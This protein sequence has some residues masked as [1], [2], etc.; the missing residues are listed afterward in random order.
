MRDYLLL[1]ING[2][3]HRVRGEHVFAPLTDYLRYEIAQC[4]TKVVCAEGDCGACTVALGKLDGSEI[5]YKPVNGCIQY[6]YQ[7]DCTHIITVEG[8]KHNGDLNAVQNAMVDCNGAQCGYCTPGFIV[9]LCSMFDADKPVSRCSLKEELA[10]NLCRCTG[11]EDIIRAGLAVDKKKQPKFNQQYPP[12]SMVKAFKEHLQKPVLIEHDGRSFFNPLDLQSAIKFKDEH[13]GAVIVSGGTDVCVIANKRG[14]A[15]PHLIST[16]HL[17]DLSAI[18]VAGETLVV[19]A[20]VTLRELEVYVRELVPEFYSVLYIFGS[21]QIRYAGT[22]VGNIAN[23]SPIADTIPFLFVT[24]AEVE[25]AGLKGNRRI[26]VNKLYKGYKTLDLSA[27]EIITRVHIPLPKKND[28][29]K[30]YKVSKREQ[31]DISSF[32]AAIKMQRSESKIA[33]VRIAY[34]GVAATV[35]ALPETETFLTGKPFAL[36]TFRAAGEIARKE[37][38]PIS[39]VR[40]SKDYRWQLAENILVKFYHETADERELACL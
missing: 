29:L 33:S 22:L 30:L 4:G 3:E 19:G 40:G 25:A 21:P 6:L 15:P 14:F 31:L 13:S 24:D 26:K 20:R 12:S 7:L 39:D 28:I 18:E 23:A 1:Y 5:V 32:T 36:D 11:Y 34:G 38:T 17:P 35:V 27:D 9:A 2:K 8:V 10:G 16:S 37:I